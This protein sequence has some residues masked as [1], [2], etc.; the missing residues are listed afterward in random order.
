[1]PAIKESERIYLREEERSF[2]QSMLQE[3]TDQPDKKSRDAFVSGSVLP[4]IQ[5]LNRQ[6]YGPDIISINKVAKGQWERRTAVS[7][8]KFST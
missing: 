5:E 4:R 8:C 1:M 2:L 3:W 6:E 7:H